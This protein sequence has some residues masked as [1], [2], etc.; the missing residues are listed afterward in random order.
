MS[1]KKIK[2]R[3]EKT[4]TRHHLDHIAGQAIVIK[5]QPTNEV[6]VSASTTK[7]QSK[8]VSP[9]DSYIKKDL[10][11]T[12]L[13]IAIFVIIITALGIVTYTTNIFNPLLSHW[14]IEY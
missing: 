3:Q 10:R 1:K 2:T 9:Q 4:V 5:S 8:T 7:K 14:N 12:V 11:R 13:T 6:I